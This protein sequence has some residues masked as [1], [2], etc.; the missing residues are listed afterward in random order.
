M[1]L[2]IKI[3]SCH[4]I[5]KFFPIF[6]CLGL[7]VLDLESAHEDSTCSND[8]IVIFD[9]IDHPDQVTK[10]DPEPCA[11]QVLSNQGCS[12]TFFYNQQLGD[13]R[14]IKKDKHCELAKSGNWRNENRYRLF[15]S[16]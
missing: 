10:F 11:L 3:A 6:F 14:C 7:A 15:K 1:K 5:H 4:I 9:S 8:V 16:K 12:S 13:C 2:G